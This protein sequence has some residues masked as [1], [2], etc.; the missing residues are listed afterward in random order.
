MKLMALAKRK[1]GLTFEQFREHY[2]TRHA[3]LARS[4]LPQI[5]SYVR[6]YVRHDLSHQSAGPEPSGEGPDFDVVTEFTFETRE[7]YERL[8]AAYADPVIQRTI[9]E[10]EE[11]FLDRAATR[12]FIVDV[13]GTDG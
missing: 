10:D 3:P 5:K 11:R 12:F 4:L 8:M 6:N 2:E 1:P 7:D 9:A 13:E